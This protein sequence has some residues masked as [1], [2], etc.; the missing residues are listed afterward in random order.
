MRQSTHLPRVPG[1]RPDVARGGRS[2]RST[3]VGALALM[4]G[5]LSLSDQAG[6]AALAI[7]LFVHGGTAALP[8]LAIRF[9]PP[10]LVGFVVPTALARLGV[11]RVLWAV[12]LVRGLL[13]AICVAAL[14]GNAPLWA[15][16]SLLGLD[17][18]CGQ[19]FRPAVATVLP[20]LSDSVEGVARAS[21]ALA[22]AKSV[23]GFTGATLGSL[24]GATV[25]LGPNCAVLAVAI[26]AAFPALVRTVGTGTGN[27]RP[28][29]QS[30]RRALPVARGRAAAVALVVGSMRTLLRG[31]W[32]GLVIV[33]A[34]GAIGIGT[35]GVALLAMAAGLGGLT[36]LAITG[37]LLAGK[38]LAPWLC[39]SITTA[40]VMTLLVANFPSRALCVAALFVWGL[41]L[42]MADLSAATV[43]PRV[44]DHRQVAAVSAVGENSKLMLEGVG[45]FGAPVLAGL[46]GA[47]VALAC[48]AEL[49]LLVMAVW[50]PVARRAETD[51]AQRMRTLGV[52]RS[53]GLFR[54]LRLD[55]I[56]TL[57]A[58]ARVVS[59]PAGTVVIAA[60]DPGDSYWIIRTGSVEVRPVG[61]PGK[62]FGPGEGFGEIALLHAVPRT[63]TVC[64]LEAMTALVVDRESFLLA[65]TGE[66]APARGP[67]PASTNDPGELIRSAP[68]VA[69]LGAARAKELAAGT[70]RIWLSAG[71]VVFRAG[72]PADACYVVLAG[73]V[74]VEAPGRTLTLGVG[75][76]FGVIGLRITGS[77]TATVTAVGDTCLAVLTA[78]DLHRAADGR[79]TDVSTNRRRG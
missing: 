3:G 73:S 74:R 27:A 22:N 30:I 11:A 63:A 6:N 60:G 40:A 18:A 62:V 64:T 15:V 25:G 56:E 43:I 78:A 51:V 48:S 72:D 32:S 5:I 33:L 12:P 71:T 70:E 34:T 17:M 10:A 19:G 47:R 1:Y 67:A 52:L 4:F 77:R 66:P 79:A 16:V 68:T 36:S 23:G 37:W 55:A 28:R 26:F 8:L 57:A 46:L 41:A 14:A 45:A 69:A 9:F 53:V 31:V 49:V 20:R 54:E 38:R 50:W 75:S 65:V 76:E 2:E 7:Y 58:G 13:M 21:A 29:V 39:G 24:L 35:R 44:V 59:V 42:A 61:R